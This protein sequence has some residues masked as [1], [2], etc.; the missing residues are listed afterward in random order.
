M[1]RDYADVRARYN[2]GDRLLPYFPTHTL[3]DRVGM[4]RALTLATATRR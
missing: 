3:E 2:V 1:R 4:A